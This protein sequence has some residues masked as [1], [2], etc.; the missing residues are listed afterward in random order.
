MRDFEKLEG[1]VVRL[2]MV[3]ELMKKDLD[4]MQENINQLKI[5][6]ESSQ[7]CKIINRKRINILSQ[8]M[9]DLNY[10]LEELINKEN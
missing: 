9:T 7:E 10:R 6:S 1:R 2:E 4:D 5:A 3:V 8:R